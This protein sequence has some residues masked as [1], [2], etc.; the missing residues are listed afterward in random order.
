MGK[1]IT[2]L[3]I[4]EE[5]VHLAKQSGINLSAVAENAIREKAGIKTVEIHNW[6]SK[7]EI[8][9]FCGREGEK[10]TKDNL[11]G[12]TWLWPDEKWICE[13]CLSQKTRY[14]KS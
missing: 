9:H 7:T 6:D 14:I 2:S 8:C 1:K 10:A 4:D 5:V 13:Q 11:E 3:N 12:L